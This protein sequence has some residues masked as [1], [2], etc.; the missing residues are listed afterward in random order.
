VS[1]KLW[2]QGW[3]VF[4]E[5]GGPGSGHH[6][7][8][9]RPGKRGGSARGMGPLIAPDIEG[10]GSESR[11]VTKLLSEN[12]PVPEDFDEEDVEYMTWDDADE[13]VCALVKVG[14]ARDLAQ[15]TGIPEQDCAKFVHQWSE[16]SNDTDMR[17]LAIQQDAAKEFGL[18]LSDW[19]KTRVEKAKTREGAASESLMGGQDKLLRAMYESTQ[20]DLAA[21]GLGPDDTVRRLFRGVQYGDSLPDWKDGDKVSF[22]GNVLESWSVS[23]DIAREFSDGIIL[24]ADVPASSILSTARS[25]FGCLN[26]GE[27]VAFGSVPGSEVLVWR[28]AE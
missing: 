27:V 8:K 21:A 24:V 11:E 17:S 10:S 12:L 15:Q 5:R 1:W 7:H 28:E 20:R 25:G 22:G 23:E 14:I 16:T 9:G 18:E 6:G 3:P 13:E 26:E 19:Q 4:V 2:H